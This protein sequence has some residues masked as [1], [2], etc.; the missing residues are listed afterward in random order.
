MDE[1]GVTYDRND[2]RLKH[3]PDDEPT[4][5]QEVYLVLTPEERAKGFIRP[6]RT[7]YLH[8]TCGSHTTMALSIAET[9][10]RNPSFYGGTFC[11][12]CEMHR[13]LDE[14]VWEDGTRVGS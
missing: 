1:K 13:P 12:K 9:Y 8:K 3:G 11:V 5:Q 2:P 4:V 10:A 14:F 6:V 7:S